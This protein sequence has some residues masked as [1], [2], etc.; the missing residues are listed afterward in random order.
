MT[1]PDPLPPPERVRVTGPARL[2]SRAR[3]RAREIDEETVLGT[4]LMGSLLRAQLRLAVL[5]LLPVVLL[6]FAMPLAFRL[7]PELTEWHLV[8]VP[9]SWLVLG[10]LIYPALFLLGWS[11]VRRAETHEREF[12]ELVEITELRSDQR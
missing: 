7:A 1:D 4:V 11:F 10:V 6:G 3:A 9:V 5:T 12:A 8:G 2:T